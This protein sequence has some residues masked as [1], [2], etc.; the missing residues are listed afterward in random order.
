[1]KLKSREYIETIISSKGA[2][3]LKIIAIILVSLLIY[4]L[5]KSNNKQRLIIISILIIIHFVMLVI[6]RYKINSIEYNEKNIKFN[7]LKEKVKTGDLILF[8]TNSHWDLIEFYFYRLL[9]TIFLNQHYSH[10]SMVLKDNNELYIVESSEEPY[11]DLNLKK[12]KAGV[13]IV[14]FERRIKDYDGIIGYKINKNN[15]E[16][17]KEE[18]NKLVKSNYSLDF[19][20]SVLYSMFSILSDKDIKSNESNGIG[21]IPFLTSL[22]DKLKL[23]NK[24]DKLNQLNIANVKS[25][26]SIFSDAYKV[27]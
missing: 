4:K 18:I 1:M 20:K 2:K 3:D 22:L 13:R 11:Y 23:Y 8:K 26:I 10:T 7:D 9:P 27:I 17:K 24:N 6:Y 21:C 16:D 5:Y 12:K 15:I 14:D 25:N 19:S